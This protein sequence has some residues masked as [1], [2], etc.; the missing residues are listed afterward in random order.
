MRTR[1]RCHPT[2]RHCPQSAATC[3]RVHKIYTKTWDTVDLTVND[4]EGGRVR[5]ATPV[6][7]RKTRCFC[8]LLSRS[9]CQV[10]LPGPT[11]QNGPRSPTTHPACQGEIAPCDGSKSRQVTD[12]L[13][14]ERVK[15]EVRR[16]AAPCLV[17]Q[18]VTANRIAA[19]SASAP[20]HHRRS[21]KPTTDHANRRRHAARG[22]PKAWLETK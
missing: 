4:K 10:A 1:G 16:L 9:N 12:S 11:R 2:G 18:A 13:D 17:G 15:W 6:Q 8:A 7:T 19:R 20:Y 22:R 21:T 14:M 5:M 3:Q